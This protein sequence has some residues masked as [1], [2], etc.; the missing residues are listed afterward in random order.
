MFG[1][2]LEVKGE[3]KLECLKKCREREELYD[4]VTKIH[5]VTDFNK[6]Y[7]FDGK[8][9][10]YTGVHHKKYYRAIMK[11]KPKEVEHGKR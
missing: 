5:E 6:T 1:G 9:T 7:G 3:T 10:V 11:L 2:I 8:K 4:Y